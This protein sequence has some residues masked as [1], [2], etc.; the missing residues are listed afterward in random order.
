LNAG[1]IPSPVAEAMMMRALDYV[2]SR[3]LLEIRALLREQ[4]LESKTRE[5]VETQS[6]QMIPETQEME[7]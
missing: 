6:S 1:S 3:T 7:H 5:E 4:Q 2:D